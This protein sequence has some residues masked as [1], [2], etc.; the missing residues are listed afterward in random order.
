MNTD[1]TKKFKII[2]S[3]GT[4]H[5]P[6]DRLFH[7]IAPWAEQH[8]DVEVV[9]QHGVSKPMAH[10]VNY[11]MMKPSVLL[12]EYRDADVVILQGGAGGVMDA[13]T[14]MRIPIIV[15]RVPGDGEVVDLHQVQ[16]SRKLS[17][18][19]IVYSAESRE[20]LWQLLDLAYQQELSTR[21]DEVKPTD[22]AA[23]A[24]RLLQALP[25]KA[26]WPVRLRRMA[27]SARGLLP[28]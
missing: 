7:W 10:A 15:P 1:E 24:I 25:A 22:G 14:A 27:R 17:E 9:A 18:M 19:G 6:F 5:L 28:R 8:C 11:T 3:A 12:E 13:R 16:F 2:A 20:R 4:Y 21:L 26:T 23:N